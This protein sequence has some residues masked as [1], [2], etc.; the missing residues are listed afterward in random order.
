[1]NNHEPE[2]ERQA[3]NNCETEDSVE[4]EPLLEKSHLNEDG[5]EKPVKNIAFDG[6]NGITEDEKRTT[7][8]SAFTSGEES[9]NKTSDETKTG[10]ISSDPQVRFCFRFLHAEFSI[11]P[12]LF[13]DSGYNLVKRNKPYN[14]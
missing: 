1:M 10:I 7:N 6:G 13:F 9:R 11:F 5:H 8:S 14:D 4:I 3:A 12:C 2:V